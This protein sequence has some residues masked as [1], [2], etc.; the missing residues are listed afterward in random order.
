MT[1]F[2]T[3]DLESNEVYQS[4]RIDRII[5]KPLKLSTLK[6]IIEEAFNSK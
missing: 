6:N 5:Q 2:E 4:A 3:A 1:A